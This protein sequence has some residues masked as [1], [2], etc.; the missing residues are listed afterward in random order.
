MKDVPVINGFYII[1]I[2]IIIIVVVVM[3]QDSSVDIA[4]GNGLDDRLIGVRIPAG[5][6]TYSLRCRVQT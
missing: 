1:I 5:S 6:G 2:I 3:S 4:T